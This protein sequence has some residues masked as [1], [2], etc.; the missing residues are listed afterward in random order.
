MP[1]PT[2]QPKIEAAAVAYAWLTHIEEVIGE[3][4]THLALYLTEGQVDA[5]LPLVRSR[6]GVFVHGLTYPDPTDPGDGPW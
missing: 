2:S 5:V 4:K 3:A 1:V 6:A